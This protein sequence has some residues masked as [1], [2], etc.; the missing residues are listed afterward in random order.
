MINYRIFIHI[1]FIKYKYYLQNIY[2]P[3]VLQNVSSKPEYFILVYKHTGPDIFILKNASY[4]L[5][6]SQKLVINF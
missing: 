6:D 3:S 4:L 2:K 5:E 1:L